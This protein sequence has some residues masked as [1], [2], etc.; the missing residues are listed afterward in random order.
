MEIT[1]D[2]IS[3]YIISG[4][5]DIQAKFSADDECK[6]I[7]ESKKV[8]LRFK[9][10]KVSLSDI[11]RSSLKDKRINAQAFL[12]KAPEKYS[13]GQIISLPYTGG[14]IDI[15]PEEA[16]SIRLK[17]M[18]PDARRQWFERKQKELAGK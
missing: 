10:D 14:V 9:M 1:K 3:D 8:T 12:R 4:E 17:A 7:G 11:I 6:K 5:F 18:T 13:N 16:M 15:D 2:K